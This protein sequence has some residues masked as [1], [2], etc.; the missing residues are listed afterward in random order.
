MYGIYTFISRWLNINA[1][2][3][4]YD[5]PGYANL[6]QQPGDV[7]TPE[8]Y[9]ASAGVPLFRTGSLTYTWE[10]ERSPAGNFGL[11]LPDGTYDPAIVPS[12][13][14]SLRTSVRVLPRVQL[15]ADIT[16]TTVRGQQIWTG[17][18]ALNI[19]IG[20]TAHRQRDVLTTA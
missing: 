8:F 11:T 12:V 5:D 20:G 18:A 13:A 2:A 4:Y 9:Q 14:H 17:L 15:T 10:R 6:W 3:Q 19:A 7:D 1:L 16:R